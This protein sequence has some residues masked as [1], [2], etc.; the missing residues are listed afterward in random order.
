M[1]K[2]HMKRYSTSLIIS[3]MQIKNYGEV[4]L[5]TGQNGHHQKVNKQ[6]FPGGLAGTWHCHCYGL[7]RSLLWC[8]FD[9]WPGNFCMLWTWPKKKSTDNKCWR[10][11]REKGILQTIGGNINWYHHYGE[12]YEVSLKS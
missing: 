2:K 1:S 12:Q 5:H 8:M 11:Y 7:L 9:L 6:E 10:G 3:E 4:L